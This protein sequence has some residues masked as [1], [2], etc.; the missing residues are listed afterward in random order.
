[1]GDD[2]PEPRLDEAPT[3][4]RKRGPRMADGPAQRSLSE[5]EKEEKAREGKGEG[6]R[7]ERWG[8]TPEEQRA[9]AGT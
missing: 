5:R 6:E 4:W 7:E 9:L 3:A 2:D 1:M 8:G